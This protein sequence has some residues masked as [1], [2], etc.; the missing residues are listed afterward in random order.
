LSAALRAITPTKTQKGGTMTLLQI[1]RNEEPGIRKQAIETATKEVARRAQAR[2]DSS[3]EL[4][5]YLFVLALITLGF[6]CGLMM[7]WKP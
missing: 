5:E 2:K 1:T 4:K 6:V 3:E 7:G